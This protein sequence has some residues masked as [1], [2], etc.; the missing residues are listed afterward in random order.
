MKIGLATD[1]TSDIPADLL[2]R[3]RIGFVPA[4][5]NIGSESFLDG[6]EISRD[7]FYN[8][9]PGLKKSPTTSSPSVGNFQTCYQDMFSSGFDHII[10][11]H[12]PKGLSGM[13]NVAHLAA[14]EFD[15]KVDIIDSGQLSLG[16]G[17]QVLAAAEAVEH[18]SV[19]SEI[20]QLIENIKKRV[21]VQALLDS[22]EYMRRSG[23]VSWARAMVGG[24]LNLKPLIELR[25]GIVDRIGLTRTRRQGI[26]RL[27]NNLKSLGDL[28]RLAILH[29]N[30]ESAARDFLEEIK[31]D[32]P[33]PAL[34]VNVT[35]VIGT[36]VG[37]NGL[38]LATIPVE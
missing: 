4:I 38:G 27:L 7:E 30:A 20:I 15:G 18:G 33:I 5:L 16:L 22:L 1:S 8:R 35:T 28:E 12:P 29:T 37:P 17:F 6:K 32:L 25:H 3:Y 36:H 21:R 11:I 9:L 34:I 26:Q 31:P 10:S 2:E 14:R 24:L 13:Y 19:L 23:R